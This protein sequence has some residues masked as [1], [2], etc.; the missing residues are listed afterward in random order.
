M[1]TPHIY[2]M[3]KPREEYSRRIPGKEMEIIECI[4]QNKPHAHISQNEK[5]IKKERPKNQFKSVEFER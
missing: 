4:R 3:I 1:T 2:S 5:E